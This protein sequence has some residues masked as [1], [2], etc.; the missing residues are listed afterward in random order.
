MTRTL[1][2]LTIALLVATPLWS[3]ETTQTETESETQTTE[4]PGLSMGTPAEG[5]GPAI[6]KPYVREATGDWEVRC[7]RTDTPEN[8]PCQLYQLL[9]DSEGNAVSEVSIFRIE[10]G[11]QAVAGANIIVPLETLLTGELSLAVDGANARRYPFS[12]CT[13]SGCIARLGLTEADV[14]SLKRGAQAQVSIRPVAAPSQTVTVNM[15]LTGFTAGYDQLP[16]MSNPG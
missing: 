14:A 11:G 15:S 16:F 1:K 13:P 7:V 9:L 5:E 4:T 6:G 8:D 12:F 3:Q 2:G 10:G